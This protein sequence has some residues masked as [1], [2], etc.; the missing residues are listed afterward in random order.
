[1]L[2]PAQMDVLALSFA[3]DSIIIAAGMINFGIPSNPK[4]YIDY[5]A[6]PGVAFK[7]TDK[8]RRD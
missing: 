3:A 2:T 7:Y 8:G 1:M 5:I 6:R 4:A